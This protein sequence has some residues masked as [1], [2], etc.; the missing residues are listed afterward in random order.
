MTQGL[1]WVA[2]NAIGQ[3]Q[4]IDSHDPNYDAIRRSIVQA[5]VKQSE[6]IV[7]DLKKVLGRGHWL[8]SWLLNRRGY[9]LVFQLRPEVA[10]FEYVGVS[11]NGAWQIKR[12][13]IEMILEDNFD[14]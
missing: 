1:K 5:T 9:R 10:R 12:N 13:V 14:N 6:D 8:P 2:L 11:R 4:K 3:I 7:E